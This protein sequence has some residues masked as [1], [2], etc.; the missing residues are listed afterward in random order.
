[1]KFYV[2][3]KAPLFADQWH[4]RHASLVYCRDKLLRVAVLSLLRTA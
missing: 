3:L 1:M 2:D 4:T